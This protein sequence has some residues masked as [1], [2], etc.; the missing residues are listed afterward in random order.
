MSQLT[1]HFLTVL[2]LV[3]GFC[4]KMVNG[5]PVLECIGGGV[6]SGARYRLAPDPDFTDPVAS[7]SRVTVATGYT[8]YKP[9]VVLAPPGSATLT[10]A[11]ALATEARSAACL[12][13]ESNKCAA[14]TTTAQPK[15]VTA[16]NATAA[17]SA[18]VSV[19]PPRT[20]SVVTA[21]LT[22]TKHLQHTAVAQT[23]V[24]V[25]A[26]AAV[27]EARRKEWTSSASPVGHRRADAS[28]RYISVP[29]PGAG[30]VQQATQSSV[31]RTAASGD[32]QPRSATEPHQSAS[33]IT[34]AHSL[35]G[36]KQLVK[37]FDPAREL[38]ERTTVS[39]AD[40][41]RSGS[42][43]DTPSLADL[44]PEQVRAHQG[45]ADQAGLIAGARPPSYK[46]TATQLG[47]R[48]AHA[49]SSAAKRRR[50]RYCLDSDSD[51][52]LADQKKLSPEHATGEVVVPFSL[53][54]SHQ[55]PGGQKQ[56]TLVASWIRWSGTD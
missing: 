2:Q 13:S 37:V 10:A 43:H 48:G 54:S 45:A 1:T 19:S 14:T 20:A 53:R 9:C 46:K 36:P 21:R 56:G 35:S 4:G 49:A 5:R 44:I 52:E 50:S 31:P 38:L 3:H 51:E 24:A 17:G 23:D 30:T 11:N 12:A 47:N 33:L 16:Q 42:Q 41:A 26:E 27:A 55:G 22:P 28:R 29:V 34:V 39:P 15:R 25:A 6:Q 18:T 32:T 7:S 40:L 8:G